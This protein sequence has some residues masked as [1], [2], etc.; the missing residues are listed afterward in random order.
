MLDEED[1]STI[2]TYCTNAFGRYWN[3]DFLKFFYMVIPLTRLSITSK[4]VKQKWLN[5][6]NVRLLSIG[7]FVKLVEPTFTVQCAW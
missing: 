6:N 4:A 2:L 7:S 1:I 5:G 3:L